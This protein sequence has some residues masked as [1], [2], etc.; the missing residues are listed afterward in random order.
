MSQF[1]LRRALAA[2]QAFL[3]E[4]L[5]QSIY[6]P[7]GQPLLPKEIIKRPDIAK[8]TSDWG[9]AGDLAFIA[10]DKDKAVGAIWLRLLKGPEKGYGYLDDET[11]ELGIALAPE[12]RGR[13]IGTLLFE[14]LFAEA[15]FCYEA[16]SLSV[17]KGNPAINLYKRQGFKTVIEENHSVIMLKSLLSQRA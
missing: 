9:K 10:F 11:P 17:S 16:V 14:R 4:M 5:Y 6:I 12:H 2:D 13:G 8:Y 1:S 7:E 15:Q 3:D